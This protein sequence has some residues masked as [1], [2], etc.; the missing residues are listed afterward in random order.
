MSRRESQP[1]NLSLLDL[2][3]SALG[4]VIFLFIITPKGGAPPAETQQMGVFVD[5]AQRKVFGLMPDSL[6]G[7]QIGDTLRIVLVDYKQFPEDQPK[8]KLVVQQ[9]PAPT[10]DRATAAPP[11]EKPEKQ[12]PGKKAEP[13]VT[14][15][16]PADQAKPEVPTPAPTP[17]PPTPPVYKG[18]AP[19]VPCLVS[20]EIRWADVAD[21]VDLFVCKDG[22]C[23][24]G[25][26]KRDRA[27]G[28]WDSG[29]SRNRLFGNDLRT[30][31]EAVR[32]FDKIQPGEYLLYAQFKN[33]D[34]NHTSLNLTGLIYTKS[35]TGQERGT[36]FSKPLTPTKDR[37]LLGKVVLKEDGNFSFTKH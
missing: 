19:S 23:V 10:P 28:E 26:H 12:E 21:N 1:F 4:A 5:T 20:F 37:V 14:V 9:P 6:V 7:K 25:G 2:L 35:P 31:Q 34:K 27:V 8:P 17:A 32:Q 11:V 13:D 24:Y 29:K 30:N 22:I 15:A 36:D 16:K 3:T 33:S 18:D